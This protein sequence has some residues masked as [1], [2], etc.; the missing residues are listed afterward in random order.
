MIILFKEFSSAQ[1]KI[2]LKFIFDFILIHIYLINENFQSYLRFGSRYRDIQGAVSITF[3][4]APGS[5]F[6]VKILAT[7]ESS[8]EF[9]TGHEFPQ[10]ES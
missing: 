3:P 7:P 9:T 2:S 6:A 8:R 4:G 1:S 10:S 5:F